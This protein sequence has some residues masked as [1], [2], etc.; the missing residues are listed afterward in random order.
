MEVTPWLHGTTPCHLKTA[1]VLASF[2]AGLPGVGGTRL[3]LSKGE[4]K[5]DQLPDNAT[6]LVWYRHTWLRMTGA[7]QDTPPP[8]T[9]SN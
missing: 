3:L 7:G 1:C 9:P 6:L 4:M 8:A 2:A 5:M